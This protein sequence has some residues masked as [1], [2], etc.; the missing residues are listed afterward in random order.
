MFSI[1]KLQK[2]PDS[3]GVYLFKNGRG[4]ILYIGKATSLR[5]RVRSYFASNIVETRGPLIVKM[6]EHSAKVDFIA[7]DSVLEALLLEAHLIKKHQP[8]HN[9]AEK[10]DKSYNYVVITDEDFPKILVMRG[11]EVAK[12]YSD[13]GFYKA[14]YGPFPNG[15]A[16]RVAMK[17]IRRIFPYR[18][19][20]C[21]PA[22]EFAASKS[23]FSR[24][25]P[26][27]N[28]QIGLCPGVCTG[29]ISKKDYA[30]TVR[31]LMMF[32]EGRK[33]ALMMTLE[34]EM[35]G[36]VGRSEFEKANETK[37]TIF[38]L[39][40]IQDVA[41]INRDSD[42]G[43]IA[44]RNRIEAYDIAHISGGSTV[45]VMTVVSHGQPDKAE[46]RMFKI[47]HPGRGDD[48]QSISE[49]LT[50]R[51][52]HNEWPIPTLIVIDGGETHLKHASETLKSYKIAVPVVSVVKDERH[53]PKDIIGDPEASKKHKTAILLA[54]AEAHRFAIRYHKK[55]RN[56][57][58]LGY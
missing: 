6:L 18:D 39:N 5:S 37:K 11:T 17:I 47:R 19:G 55:L 48:I 13:P 27:F 38:A 32:F 54:N 28:R 2:L 7:T 34:K 26:C 12:S 45:G 50:R 52:A 29:E 56:Q 35:K 1:K 36:Y 40:H 14:L 57:A 15:S 24:P 3:P 4:Q 51:F 30:K 33:K 16:L 58:F 46:Y 20:K 49:V 23:A 44:G 10:D 31:H 9:T 22:S 8:F 43:N 42:I 41:L 25:R 53:R 21:V